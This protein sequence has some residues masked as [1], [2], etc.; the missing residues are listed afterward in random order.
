[1][2]YR[3]SCGK[4][5]RKQH[6]WSS[7]FDNSVKF[8][9]RNPKLRQLPKKVCKETSRKTG[10]KIFRWNSIK[11]R[12]R[13]NEDGYQVERVCSF[14]FQVVA[15]KTNQTRGYSRKFK[16]DRSE[17]ISSKKKCIER[18]VHHDNFTVKSAVETSVVE[19]ARKKVV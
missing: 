16:V 4:T 5:Y 12:S 7:I 14:S 9:P 19:E 6:N 1:M 17:I 13:R 18:S 15:T 11:Y 10:V 3:Q 8:V 2:N